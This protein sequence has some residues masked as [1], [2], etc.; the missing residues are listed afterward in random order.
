[1]DAISKAGLGA[2]ADSVTIRLIPT[3]NAQ[4]LG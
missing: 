3:T 1:M 4:R 2:C